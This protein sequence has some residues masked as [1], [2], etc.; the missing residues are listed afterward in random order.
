MANF[1]KDQK[2]NCNVRNG[3]KNET[4]YNRESIMNFYLFVA[5][6][7]GVFSFQ[8]WEMD[9]LS[10]ELWL[11]AG[12]C[13]I[14]CVAVFG[15][16]G[17]KGHTLVSGS[18]TLAPFGTGRTVWGC[19][20]ARGI[21]DATRRAMLAS[22]FL[23][24]LTGQTHVNARAHTVSGQKGITRFGRSEGWE[25]LHLFP[26]Q[27]PKPDLEGRRYSIETVSFLQVFLCPTRFFSCCFQRK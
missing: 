6:L 18:L 4:L 1:L 12:L 25:I 20:L 21:W 27:H 7:W 9:S 24:R 26:V 2:R 15:S 8:I 10:E 23:T 16:C 11:H 5:F 13:G 22:A 17:W 19:R 3:L 14:R